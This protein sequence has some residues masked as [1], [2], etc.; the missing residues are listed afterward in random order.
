M[1]NNQFINILSFSVIFSYDVELFKHNLEYIYEKF[2]SFIGE[3]TIIKSDEISINGYKHL[4]MLISKYKEFWNID[5]TIKDI[6]V[7]LFIVK[8]GDL[9][10]SPK[11]IIHYYKKCINKDTSTINKYYFNGIHHY[12]KN[13]IKIYIDKTHKRFFKLNTIL[14]ND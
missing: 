3:D 9:E 1:T 10:K 13:K 6:N 5:L 8:A 12:W 11:Q 2:N 7:I 14:E 4:D